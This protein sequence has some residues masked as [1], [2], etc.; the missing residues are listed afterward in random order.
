MGDSNSSVAGRKRDH[1]RIALGGDVVPPRFRDQFDEVVLIHEAL[2]EVSFSDV[3]TSLDF[4]GKKLSAP[5]LVGAMTG[6]EAGTDIINANLAEAVEELG[7]GM[8]VGSQR[9]ALMDPSVEYTF[10]IVRDRAP[11]AL[12]LANLG[13]SNVFKMKP[14]E[15]RR[16]V[17]M[18]GAD[19]LEIHLNMLQELVQPEGEPDFRGL[20]ESLD[21]I[22]DEAGVPVLLKETGSGISMETAKRLEDK[23]V[24][25]YDI[26][27]A[28]G[29][30][31]AVIEGKRRDDDLAL[32]FFDWGIPTV[33]SL[34][35][36]RSVSDKPI[37]ASG[38]LRNGLDA[39]K[40]LVLGA[41]VASMARPL[42]RPA[43]RS[44]E[45]VKRVLITVQKQMRMGMALV[46][47]RNVGELRKTKY[48]LLGSMES[49][50]RQRGLVT[51][52]PRRGLARKK[53]GLGSG[54]LSD[55]GSG[56]C[57]TVAQ[58]FPDF[59]LGYF[60]YGYRPPPRPEGRGSSSFRHAVTAS[61]ANGKPINK[62][63][64]FK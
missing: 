13:G 31:F 39:V 17:E 30:S 45:D 11:K 34:L 10:R 62:S 59:A 33:A 3:D 37:I 6:G 51:S 61:C 50:A 60:A 49:W 2:P 56:K 54:A 7:L 42:L 29:T 8:G 36:V 53:S 41:T 47:A 38:G 55:P 40:S 1:I 16:A 9:P 19:A 63:D 35:E 44:S 28:G 4:L 27:G 48:V 24:F 43:T 52:A 20:E 21:A 25:G 22:C 32:P 57:T 15:I 5:L 26:G 18:I 58:S 46:N 23:K 12:L 64:K 14:S